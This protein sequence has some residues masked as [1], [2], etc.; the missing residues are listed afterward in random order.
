MTSW[1]GVP[2]SWP[3]LFL[4]W[5]AMG[6]PGRLLLGERISSVSSLGSSG[7]GGALWTGNS[8]KLISSLVACGIP[9]GVR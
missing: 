6:C 7:G 1:W 4:M 2:S 3:S 9:N 8:N 5:W